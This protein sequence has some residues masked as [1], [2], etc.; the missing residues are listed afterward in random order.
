MSK[1]KVVGLI[2]GL[3]LLSSL[4]HQCPAKAIM[5]TNNQASIK[6]LLN[7]K[8]HPGHYLL[9]KVNDATESLHSKQDQVVRA[10]KRCQAQQQGSKWAD[11]THRVIDLQVHWILGHM[12]FHPNKRADEL[13]KMAAMGTS[14][15][16]KL[17]PVFLQCQL[18]VSISA[19]CQ[20][21]VDKI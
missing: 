16:P 9:D 1:A 18:P 17:L 6:A 14:S 3:H 5:G 13:A 21:N 10:C 11:Q 8:P 4:G 15:D 19:A 7:Q 12:E 20:D 2:L